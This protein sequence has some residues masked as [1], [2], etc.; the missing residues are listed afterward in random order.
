V[1]F[2]QTLIEAF[3]RGSTAAA[4][5]GPGPLERVANTIPL[6]CPEQEWLFLAGGVGLCVVAWG[7]LRCRDR[8]TRRLLIPLAIQH[9]GVVGFSLLDIQGY[10]DYMALLYSVAFFLGATWIA[11]LGVVRP[12]CQRLMIRTW[13]KPAATRVLCGT[14]VLFAFIAARPGPWRPPL[15]LRAPD[16]RAGATL[17]DQR[18]VAFSLDRLVG[19]GVLTALDHIELLFLNQRVNPLPVAYFNESVHQYFGEPGETAE[20]TARRMVLSTSPNAFLLPKQI[21]PGGALRT[22]FEPLRLGSDGD[23]YSAIAYLEKSGSRHAISTEQ[24]QRGSR[25]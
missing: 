19:D 6:V 11:V 3:A 5:G 15:E 4:S 20:E 24:K 13:N 9:Y 8:D 17:A 21:S 22:E 7:L 12:T 2:R 18:Q 23:R 16:I 1:T 14:L 25:P 10:A